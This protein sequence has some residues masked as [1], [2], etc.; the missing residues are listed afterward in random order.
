VPN[1]YNDIIKVT[2][3]GHPDVRGWA[4][5]G[6]PVVSDKPGWEALGTVSS[7]LISGTYRDYLGNEFPVPQK[8]AD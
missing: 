5:K 6:L 2:K 4:G 8:S 7:T 1:Q 3:N